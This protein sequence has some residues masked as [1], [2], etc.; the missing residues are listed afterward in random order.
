MIPQH[1][2]DR[3]Q[4]LTDSINQTLRESTTA[5]PAEAVRKVFI[6][7]ALYGVLRRSTAEFPGID[8]PNDGLF[9]QQIAARKAEV[10]APGFASRAARRR[11]LADARAIER[12]AA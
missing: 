1:F 11:A 7:E 5:P 12:A 8:F 10:T 3:A 9:E 4:S 2:I 6:A